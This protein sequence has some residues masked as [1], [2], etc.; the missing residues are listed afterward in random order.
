VTIN[1]D[2][3]PEADELFTV[4][5]SGAANASLGDGVGAGTIVNDDA[6]PARAFVSVVGLDTNDCSNIAT[7]CRTLNAAIVQVAADGE[8]IVTKTGSYAGA[9]VTK[10][11]K[12]SAAPGIV[13]FSGQPVTVNAPGATVVIRGLTIK[14]LTPGTGQGVLVQ[15]AGAVFV[16][17]SVIDGWDVGIRLQGGAEL[18]VKDTTIRNGNTGVYATTGKTSLDSARLLS[19]GTGIRAEGAELSVRG[20]TV[21]GNTTAGISASAGAS[22]TVEKCQI[23]NNGKGIT[24]PAA[25]GATVRLSRSVVSGNTLGLENLGGTLEVSGNNAVRGNTTNTSGTIVPATLQ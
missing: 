3:E 11:V 17:S 22:V 12:L 23:A 5:L 19:N 25:S 2:G 8:V 10:G 14:A 7:P 9:T 1:G 6:G 15:S 16:E 18:F 21:A 24:L 20:S 4:S 13:A